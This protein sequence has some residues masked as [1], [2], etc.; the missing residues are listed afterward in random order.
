MN[1]VLIIGA[2]KVGT[3]TGLALS[4]LVDYHDPYKGMVNDNFNN[5]DYIIV[6][7]DTLQT[8]PNDY[9][10]LENVLAE[11]NA[12]NYLGIV[13]IRSTVSPVRVTRWESSYGFSFILF[14]E[15]MSQRDDAL[16]I[17]KTWIAVL[18]GDESVNLKFKSD[19]LEKLG[20]PFKEETFMS[21]SKQESAVIKLAD[22]AALSAKLIYFNAIYLIC[23]M[24]DLDYENVR[25]AISL[26]SRINGEHS[27]VPSPDDGKLGFGGHCLPKDLLAIAE[28]DKLGLFDKI[29]E[30]NSML[31]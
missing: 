16:V 23:K 15:F 20:Y 29:K 10:D 12:H 19:V 5:Y 27:A 28:L 8:G 11:I 14:P 18:G 17:D 26:D 2:G 13:V 30:I 21:V 22:N 4:G 25:K 9:D 1:N 3:A 31:R 7:V 6:C 24:F